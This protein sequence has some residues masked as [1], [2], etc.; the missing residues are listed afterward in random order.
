VGK[1]STPTPAGH[2]FVEEAVALTPQDAGAPFALATSARSQVLQ[3]FDGGPR[4]IA[5]HGMG[6]LYGTLVTAVSHAA[7]A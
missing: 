6:N 4:Q 5:L 2:F 3:E 7:S 1:P